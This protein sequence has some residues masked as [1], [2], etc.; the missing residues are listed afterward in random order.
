MHCREKSGQHY[1]VRGGKQVVSSRS[2]VSLNPVLSPSNR[3]GQIYL[4]LLEIESTPNLQLE[5][6][7]A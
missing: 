6:L 5:W 3:G 4:T 7:L 1:E 2:P